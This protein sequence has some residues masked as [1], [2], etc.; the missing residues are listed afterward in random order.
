IGVIWDPKANGQMKVY[1]FYG[2]FYYSVPTDLNVRAYGA[3]IN[4][5]T[6][7]FDPIDT[8]QNANVIGHETAFFQGGVLAEPV[9]AGIKG[10]Y[11][12]EYSAGMDFLLDPT[13]SIGVKG[14]YRNLGRAIE[15]RCDLDS[16]LEFPENKGNTC[17]IMNPGSDG[18]FASGNF[19]GC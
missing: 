7:N 16:S 5:S 1:A 3:Q 18:T 12:D 2:R 4:A 17:G 13:F 6:W 10:I 8:T 9:D 19:H 11:Q 14:T 15:D